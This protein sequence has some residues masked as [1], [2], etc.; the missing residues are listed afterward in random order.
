MEVK[1]CSANKQKTEL[2]QCPGEFQHIKIKVPDSSLHY[3]NFTA[4]TLCNNAQY[5]KRTTVRNHT[6]RHRVGKYCQDHWWQQMNKPPPAAGWWPLHPSCRIRRRKAPGYTDQVVQRAQGTIAYLAES[7][8]SSIPN[9][10][11]YNFVQWSTEISFPSST[12]AASNNP[13]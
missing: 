13:E 7:G 2:T 8:G 3:C 4:S 6:T 12:L 10:Y 5:D 1:S 9:T 11:R